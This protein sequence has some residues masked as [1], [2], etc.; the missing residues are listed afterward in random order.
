[1]TDLLAF[2]ERSIVPRGRG[3]YLI[4]TGLLIADILLQKVSVPG[5]TELPL[6]AALLPLV[7]GIGLLGG[8][9][10]VDVKAL[11]AYFVFVVLVA[12]SAGLSISP[13]LSLPSWTM[14]MVMLFPFTLTSGSGD[15]AV[16]HRVFGSVSN[17]LLVIAG[18]GIL[19][20]ILQGLIDRTWLFLVDY[21]MPSSIFLT[22]YNNLNPLFYGSPLLKSNG[23]FLAEP[24]YFSQAVALGIIIEF[25]Y[26]RRLWVLGV[27]GAA[28]FC[29]F[30]GTG[31]ILLIGW[32]LYFAYKSKRLMI[33]AAA[34]TAALV[35]LWAFG[36]SVGLD[37]LF[38]RSAEFAD[39][40]SSGFARFLSMFYVIND[41]ILTDPIAPFFGRGPGTVTEYFSRFAFEAHDP[42]WGKLIYE[43]GLLGFAAFMVFYGLAV[44]RK[45]GP[46]VLPVSI[47]YFFLGGY[48]LDASIITIL[49]SLVVWLPSSDQ[50]EDDSVPSV[51]SL[52][53]QGPQMLAYQST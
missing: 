37:V 52:S 1:V 51:S 3:L 43:Y 49:A 31:I 13:S 41:V 45:A 38:E 18:L 6:L 36:S 22:G 50:A 12:V 16:R 25:T 11:S 24:S 27:Q 2:S 40:N 29:S 46:F 19:Q 32:A 35:G 34:L 10:H 14:T 30:S 48:L 33:V 47:L 4:C 39:K 17:F 28:M 21:Q 9:L 20:F 53:G 44:V 8:T 23:L 26:R 42:T 5:V 7:A 15:T